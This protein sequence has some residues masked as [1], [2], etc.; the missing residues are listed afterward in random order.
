MPVVAFL[1]SANVGGHHV[2]KSREVCDR[3][4]REGVG[5][6][7]YGAAGTFIVS[8]VESV[9]QVESL[10]EAVIPFK[11]AI[12][13]RALDQIQD[14]AKRDPFAR[15]RTDVG[16]TRYASFLKDPPSIRPALPLA[17]PFAK[18]W[19][20]KLVGFHQDTVLSLYRR[21]AGKAIDPNAVVE[22]EFGCPATS[23]NWNTVLSLLAFEEK[24]RG[25]SSASTRKISQM[26]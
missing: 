2:F 3:L 7:S 23:R 13:T 1:R 22:R 8:G 11:T 9:N 24:E 18:E 4:R 16:I 12:I 19:R 21:V 5:A 20:V 6:V 14:L 10:V 25:I 15:A 26:R 17:R